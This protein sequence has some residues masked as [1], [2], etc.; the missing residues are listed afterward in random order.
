[1]NRI[2]VEVASKG[3]YVLRYFLSIAVS[4]TT[5]FFIAP[6]QENS[7]LIFLLAAAPG[8]LIFEQLTK[9]LYVGKMIIE[10]N[11]EG[12][13]F[14]WIKQF[15]FHNKQNI[16]LQW[17]EISEHSYDGSSHLDQF[18]LKLKSGKKMKFFFRFMEEG[19]M[20]F[21]H[22]MQE[23]TGAISQVDDS[24]HI[25][26]TVGF[27]E[28]EFGK[29]LVFGFGV[30]ILGTCGFALKVRNWNEINWFGFVV[31]LIMGLAMVIPK[32]KHIVRKCG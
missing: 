9:K 1:M 3:L 13:Q 12:L 19:F 16:S 27:F 10:M 17:S 29:W 23:L 2:E 32:I 4:L 20:D 30:L 21:Y 15:I 28:T 22:N 26:R 24:V 31:L 7:K 14:I 6:P 8:Y 25:S 11:K 18:V 5:A